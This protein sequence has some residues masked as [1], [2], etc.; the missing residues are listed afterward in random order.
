MYSKFVVV[1]LRISKTD[2]NGKYDNTSLFLGR[3]KKKMSRSLQ[4]NILLTICDVT[5]VP[6]WLTSADEPK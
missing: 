5:N 6:C 2:V 3:K 4:P 1:E